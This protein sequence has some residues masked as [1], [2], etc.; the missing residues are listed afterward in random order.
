MALMFECSETERRGILVV[1]APR[2]IQVL[3]QASDDAMCSR[4]IRYPRQTGHVK[5]VGNRF[6]NDYRRLAFWFEF[7]D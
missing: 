7:E 6:V 5:I 3:A 1:R 2:L 4:V